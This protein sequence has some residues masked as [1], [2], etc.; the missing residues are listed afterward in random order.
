MDRVAN[1]INKYAHRWGDNTSARLLGWVDAYDDGKKL[2]QD[3]MLWDAF[4][5]DR[6]I[7]PTHNGH[8]LLA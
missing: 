6:Q 7:D 4:C 2:L 8:D 1:L 5:I 3:Q